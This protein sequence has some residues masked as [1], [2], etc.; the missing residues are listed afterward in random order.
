[1][2]C[3]FVFLIDDDDGVRNTLY[4]LLSFA[5][6]QVRCWSDART[7][8]EQVP[9]VAPAV[10]LTDMRMPGLTGVE[11]H[12]EL[13]RRGRTIPVV[14]LSGESTVPQT[15]RAMKLGAF[16]FLLK[17]F[18]REELLR[19]VAAALEA[20]RLALQNVIRKAR[21]DQAQASLSPRERQVHGLLLKG[22]SNA[23]IVSE[24]GVSLP[25]A[26]QYKAEVM[27]K[28]GVKSL[29]ELISR[30]ASDVGSAET[31]AGH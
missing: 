8:L 18:S 20:D 6:Y 25:T 19:V 27:R 17:P 26:K 16:D 31:L 4:D 28:L 15:V 9:N 3:G 2:S 23:E 7:F 10:L 5:G 1:M 11:L 12:D 30:S 13:V 22:Y 24:L 14:Y 21:N 29:A